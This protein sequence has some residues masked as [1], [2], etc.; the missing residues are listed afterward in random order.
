MRD[1][2]QYPNNQR[3]ITDWLKSVT[4][5]LNAKTGLK[6]MKIRSHKKLIMGHVNIN[7][8]RARKLEI[9]KFDSLGYM[10][11]KNIA[12]FLISET[13]LHDSFLSA[14]FKIEGFTIPYRYERNDKGVG[15]SI[16]F[17]VM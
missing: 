9:D 13:K 8:V 16:T 7:S 14:Q 17:I 5:Y 1:D 2:S 12:M 4:D 15:H 11:D 3:Y 10:L 6:E